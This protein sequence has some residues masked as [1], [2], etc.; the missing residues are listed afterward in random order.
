MKANRAI[1]SAA[2]AAC[3]ALSL[4][5]GACAAPGPTRVAAPPPA[6]PAPPPPPP[7]P[8][9]TDWRDAPATPG[10]WQW[11]REGRFSTA[12]F[13]GPGQ[14]ALLSLTCNPQGGT[15]TLSRGGD[16]PGAATTLSISTTSLLRTLP[17][18]P[19]A[20]PAIILSALDPLFDAMAFSRGRFA[21]EVPG[22]VPLYLPSWPEVGRVIE[23]CR[24]AA[25]TPDG[26][27]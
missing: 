2:S 16:Q 14:P 19:G 1:C 7:P 13:G 9:A 21:V 25:R 20:D 10:D 26:A 11:S 5:L 18:R 4:L 22:M 24:Q 17:I 6:H 8:V 27:G 23:D 12:R 15:I 3:A